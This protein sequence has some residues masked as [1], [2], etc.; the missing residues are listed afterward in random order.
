MVVKHGDWQLIPWQ[1]VVPLPA[2]TLRPKR[3]VM[4]Q[5]HRRA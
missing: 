1:R 5:I 3:G 4:V 2:I